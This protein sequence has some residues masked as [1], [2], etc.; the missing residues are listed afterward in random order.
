MPVCTARTPKRLSA[1]SLLLGFALWGSPQGAGAK[2]VNDLQGRLPN[3]LDM[4]CYSQVF[5]EAHLAAHPKQRITS[6]ALVIGPL[7]LQG[8]HGSRV[9]PYVI[10]TSLK[11]RKGSFWQGGDCE[12]KGDAFNCSADCDGGSVTLTV[13]EGG[14]GLHLELSDRYTFQGGCGDE[15]K[16]VFLSAKTEEPSYAL[17]AREMKVCAS[18]IPASRQV[19]EWLKDLM[20]LKPPPAQGKSK[21]VAK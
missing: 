16:A 11:G 13:P 12:F 4:K 7:E 5:D 2:V 8:H 19:R 6:M 10:V 21:S 9:W 3:A 15:R 1:V 18:R 20:F 17:E 14:S